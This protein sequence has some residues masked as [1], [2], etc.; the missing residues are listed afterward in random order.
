MGVH[1]LQAMPNDSISIDLINSSTQHISLERA[2]EVVKDQTVFHPLAARNSRIPA[3][4]SECSFDLLNRF[5]SIGENVVEANSSGKGG[6]SILGV[7]VQRYVFG[8]FFLGYFRRE[9]DETIFLSTW[10][11]FKL[12][13]SPRRIPVCIASS[14]IAFR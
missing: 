14:I 5:A 2:S 3:S 6:Q 9:S 11:H 8:P 4:S 13:S 10:L 1:S 12:R 7:F